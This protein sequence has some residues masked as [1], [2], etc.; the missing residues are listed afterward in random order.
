MRARLVTLTCFLFSVAV[1]QAAVWYVSPSGSD[2]ADGTNWATAKA[3]IQA[4]VNAAAAGD[5]V[6]VTNGWYETGGQKASGSS[7]T[8]RVCVTQA[9]AVVSVNGPEVTTIAG[10]ATNGG[11][12]V[13]GV[14]LSNGAVLHG[15]TVTR[16]ATRTSGSYLD[17]CAGGILCVAGTN[18]VVSNCVIA[19]NSAA[20]MGGGIYDGLVV[21]CTLASNAAPYGGGC[22]LSVV[23]DSQVRGNSADSYGGGGYG[24][25]FWNC[26]IVSNAATE[27]GGGVYDSTAVN[28]LLTGNAA[29]YGGGGVYGYLY[30]CT[31]VGNTAR[32]MGGGAIAAN[33]R[34]SIL[35]HNSAPEASNDYA[36]TL[37][38]CCTAPPVAGEGNLDADP[39]LLCRANPRLRAGSPCIDAGTNLPWVIGGQDLADRPRLIGER[40][41]LGAYEFQEDGAT[42]VI[43]AAI[44]VPWTN[45]AVLFPTPFQADIQGE[46]VGFAWSWG[47]GGAVANE[48]R[49]EH[50]FATAGVYQVVL[51]ASNRTVTA[52]AT[53]TVT[54][55]ENAVYYVSPGAGHVSPFTNWSDAATDIQ[56][57]VD[58]AAAGGRVL[59]SNGT[60]STGGAAG[61]PASSRLT[62]R[63]AI[64]RPMTVQSVNGPDVTFIVGRRDAA[65]NG[66]AAVRGVYL[67]D[68]ASLIGFTVTNGAT[69]AGGNLTNE[70]SG[71]GILCAGSGCTISNCVVRNGIAKGGG[72][73]VW[74]GR[75]WNSLVMAN[76]ASNGAGAY[77]ASLVDSILE[78]NS[79]RHSG[80]GAYGGTL[81]GCMVTGNYANG[82]GG[83]L[84]GGTCSN[85]ALVDNRGDS[86]GGGAYRSL[87]V[88]C[89]LSSN[90]SKWGS[91]G[92]LSGGIA[93]NCV[94]SSNWARDGGGACESA[95]FN[96]VLSNNTSAGFGGGAYGCAVR[97]C[98][99]VGNWGT[100]GG[101]ARSCTVDCS[102]IEGNRAWEYGG[103]T[104]HGVVRDSTL[105]GN[106][107]EEVGGG[108][109]FGTLYRCVI[110]D[111]EAVE[112]G[113][114]EY[115]AALENCAVIGNHSGVGGGGYYGTFTNCTVVGNSALDCGGTY[116]A[117]VKNSIVYFN[118]APGN[119]NHVSCSFS[120]SCAAPP[121]VGEGNLDADPQLVSFGNPRLL[122]G[123][124]CIDAGTNLP[125][126]SS[127]TDLN[128]RARIV[129]D[130]VDIGACEFDAG[131]LT[132]ALSAA[133][134]AS[135]TQVCVGFSAPFLTDLQG[136]VQ[137]FVWDWGDGDQTVNAALTRHAYAT[138]GTYQVVLRATNGASSAAATVTV[139]VTAMTLYVAPTGAHVPPFASWANAAT[140]IQ[141]AVN[142]SVPGALILVTN[143]VYAIGSASNYPAG[144]TTLVTR[145][146]VHRPVTV[147]SV[148]GPAVTTIRGA[149]DPLRTNGAG[150]VRCLYLTNGAAVAGFTLTGGA[151][152]SNGTIETARSA[153]GVW[154]EGPDAV[155]SNCVIAGNVS[156][157]HAGGLYGG[158]CFD[159]TLTSNRTWFYGGGARRSVL[160]R[161]RVEANA[162]QTG[163]G[164]HESESH[165]CIYRGNAANS[166]GAVCYGTLYNCVLTG[167]RAIFGGGGASYAT[168]INCTV[169]NNTGGGVD[170][171]T[172]VNSI[173]YHNTADG[174]ANVSDASMTNSCATPAPVHGGAMDKYPR[175]ASLEE[176]RLMEA[177]PCIDAGENQPWMIGANDLAGC[178]RIQNGRVDIGAYEASAWTGSLTAACTADRASVA[179][180]FH[181]TFT[182]DARGN[183]QGFR[184]SWGDG[185]G[186]NN[187]VIARHAFSAPGTYHVGLVASNLTG[188]A[189]A[190]VTVEVVAQPVHY[191]SLSGGHVPPY[192]SWANAATTIQAAVDA[193]T[194]PG[195][196]VL[197][198][199]GVYETGYATNY[200]GMAARVAVHKPVEIR[201]VNGPAETF[202]KGRI[203]GG[204]IRAVYLTDCATLSGFSVSSGATISAKNGGGVLCGG[205]DAVISNCVISGCSAAY[206]GGGVSGG[207]VFN[208]LIVSNQTGLDGGGV[209]GATVYDS[210]V[211]GNFAGFGGGSAW[212]R[213]V[214]CDVVGNR[215]LHYG[216]GVEMGQLENCVV[217]HNHA[218]EDGGGSFRSTMY[219]TLVY[220]NW[221]QDQAGGTFEGELY[222]CTVVGNVAQNAGGGSDDSALYNCIVY[223]N[224][225]RRASNHNGGIFHR[226]C[227]S[228][229]PPGE[230]NIDSPPGIQSFSNARLLPGSPCIDS[231]IAGSWASGA[232]DLAGRARVSGA[233]PDIGAYEFHAGSQTGALTALPWVRWTNV[234][235]GCATTFRSEFTG[236]ATGFGWSWGDG[237]SGGTNDLVLSHAFATAGVYNVVLWATNLAQSTAGT[238][239]VNVVEQPIHYVSLS[240]GNVEPYSSWSNAA[241][242]IQAAVDAA[243]VPGAL[244]LVTNGVYETGSRKGYPTG[245]VLAARVCIDKPVIVRSVNGPEVTIIKGKGPLGDSAIRCV[246]MSGDAMLAGFTMTTGMTR[247]VSDD[248]YESSGAAA[249][250]M[251]PDATISNCVLVNN[252][253]H[254]L[255][256]G[257][258]DGTL[259]DCVV[260]SNSA[261]WFG[262]GAFYSR[263]RNCR[264][265]DNSAMYGGGVYASDIER[266]VIF[267]NNAARG[268]GAYLADIRN[269]VLYGNEAYQGG[270]AYGGH[271][272]NCT[273]TGNLGTNGAGVRSVAA[274][275]S[276]VYGN[277]DIVG[278][279]NN[280]GTSVS[281]TN[282]CTTPDPGGTGNIA[283]D[284]LFCD[285]GMGRGDSYVPGNLHLRPGSPC[286]NAGTNEPWMAGATD[287]DGM[288]RIADGI[289]DM[290]AY[291]ATPYG[292]DL[293]G[294]GLPDWWEMLYFQ[295]YTN[296]A[297]DGD[298][299]M[300]QLDNLGEFSAGTCPT[301]EDTDGDHFFDGDEVLAGTQATNSAS[302]L[303]FTHLSRASTTGVV[304]RWQSVAGKRYRL[305]QNSQPVTGTWSLIV[306]S[307]TAVPPQ[308]VYTDNAAIGPRLYRVELE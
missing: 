109:S 58:V 188:S 222:N 240:G 77:G 111:N 127:G 216:G 219:N 133:C 167:N 60:Y 20:S 172:V 278:A 1:A 54:V 276:I 238:V 97:A 152:A 221:C 15:F 266:C 19:G 38:F 136:D 125:G 118:Q 73:G 142:A 130:T 244:V 40:L 159:C 42:G 181:V 185:T 46:A 301:N 123:S 268:G 291:E 95:L 292:S 71:A 239:T 96:C 88:D 21:N 271:M 197:V 236:D 47:D 26:M 285:P 272:Y 14:Y 214:R 274:L 27:E 110:R 35:Y 256:G 166:G 103:G 206:A 29:R 69:L 98:T 9:V 193:S 211:Q 295:T 89:S 93:S 120:S 79:A 280:W 106:R 129:A 43:S 22:S 84:W 184:W 68:G 297:P 225:A 245:M 18:V 273:V 114:G 44:G 147:R 199:N 283:A 83:G 215:A 302:F 3:T 237:T 205:A 63:V 30:G 220:S 192:D 124:P 135:W 210:L 288:P 209:A 228:P 107:S 243:A 304:V 299:D 187:L 116:A 155:L 99:L 134:S 33:A 200:G 37:S 202:I 261:V 267:H 196:L 117:K 198:T 170:H 162:S 284:P 24:A 41:D 226:V 180:G 157:Y 50:A 31:V 277:S 233:T 189:G 112:S 62:N 52:A 158:T 186:T 161:C 303:G 4:G 53:V 115:Y 195:A 203:G 91:G 67:A 137:G 126:Q 144:V 11:L 175:L 229:R 294:D 307:V 270:G 25:A 23:R 287:L 232:V 13:R 65:T 208:S 217:R 234:A 286:L 151:T 6:L 102:R 32:E 140:T 100:Q 131:G 263:L 224:H 141:A 28:C 86:G 281:M 254:Y 153:G 230:G 227:T 252:T 149:W 49:V 164:T 101:G 105:A 76:A 212:G 87:L 258:S 34:N 10:R 154:C 81:S 57:A 45:A 269:S 194:V 305:M 39:M 231:G 251:H 183:A 92:G 173:V 257:V 259:V 150:A 248:E 160:V 264:V 51:T 59:V 17:M 282:C 16:G 201:S 74:G 289:V 255:A 145:A 148:N 48:E 85:G 242:T 169:V 308:N 241:T 55:V 182:A 213:L 5:T 279:A 306:G 139:V 75:L 70:L 122:P 80:G 90:I 108:A 78:R 260:V 156:A 72:G 2:A 253:A 138:T 246:V 61:Y 275:N 247:K 290:G 177:S 36:N 249:W 94:F 119:S 265:E 176:P 163:A 12:A 66:P 262:G 143:G 298:D 178:A 250:C 168:L 121:A 132:G 7:L 179:V 191:V 174:A 146:A 82:W 223:Y 190:T 113:G 235:T 300:D 293:D 8:N 64:Y 128:G 165:N 296:A 218:G 204:P 104:M 56:S 171:G 207:T